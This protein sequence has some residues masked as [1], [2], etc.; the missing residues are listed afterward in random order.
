MRVRIL[1]FVLVCAAGAW[2]WQDSLAQLKLNRET[3]ERLITGYVNES[4]NRDHLTMPPYGGAVKDA[5]LAMSDGGR[6]AIV[7]ELGLAA[8]TFVMSPAFQASYETYIKNA[9]NAVNHGI[10]ITSKSADIEAAMKKGDYAAVEKAGQNMMRDSYRQGVI[11]RLPS[12]ANYDKSTIEMMADTDAGMV[13]I[14]DP[15]TAAEKAAVAKA[16]V[17]LGEAKKLAATDIAKARETYKAALMTAAGLK[18]EADAKSSAEEAKKKEEQQRYNDMLL[19][20]RMKKRLLEFA[21]VVK[22]VDF[23][24]ATTMKNNKKVFVSPANERR[25]ELWKMLYRLGP[26]GAN[27]AAQVA[28]QWAAEL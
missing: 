11:Q 16:K 5:L 20:P 27:A 3:F 7:K 22:T 26:G 17:M 25:S 4:A 2:A 6:A 1:G 14:S 9:Y 8:K 28:Q 15:K 24:A 12:L 23:N 19:K 10:T 21:A 18:D 13:D